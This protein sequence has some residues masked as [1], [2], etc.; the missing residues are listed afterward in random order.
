M[1]ES[2]SASMSAKRDIKVVT[3]FGR[4]EVDDRRE[5]VQAMSYRRLGTGRRSC[6]RLLGWLGKAC[7]RGEQELRL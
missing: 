3:A 4:M 7:R 6:C 5:G 2:G 1:V